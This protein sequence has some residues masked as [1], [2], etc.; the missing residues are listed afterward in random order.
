MSL[1]HTVNKSAMRVSLIDSSDNLFHKGRQQNPSITFR[2]GLLEI[3]RAKYKS[4][5]ANR[6]D[7]V[8]RNSARSVEKCIRTGE[9][10]WRAR[11]LTSRGS[12]L[13]HPLSR[14]EALAPTSPRAVALHVP[15]IYTLQ[16]C[17]LLTRCFSRPA[18]FYH[19]QQ[20]PAAPRFAYRRPQYYVYAA[21]KERHGERMPLPAA[22]RDVRVGACDSLLLDSPYSCG[23]QLIF[24]SLEF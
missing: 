8:R 16:Q 5:T 6:S 14:S 10:T 1:S 13:N 3:T 17:R 2:E 9:V 21:E 20:Q 19:Q 22:M 12:P 24:I 4:L 7:G 23:Y 11:S 15:F 18:H